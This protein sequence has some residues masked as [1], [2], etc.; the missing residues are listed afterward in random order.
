MVLPYRPVLAP[1][2]GPL[3]KPLLMYGEIMRTIFAIVSL[4]LLQI[5]PLMAAD[6]Q[7]VVFKM[8]LTWEAKG[9]N[10]ESSSGS[11]VGQYSPSAAWEGYSGANERLVNQAGYDK[12]SPAVFYKQ[13][14]GLAAL[15]PGDRLQFSQSS[16][17]GTGKTEKGCTF[18]NNEAGQGNVASIERDEHGALLTFCA[19]CLE[20]GDILDKCGYTPFFTMEYSPKSQEAMEQFGQFKLSDQELKSFKSLNKTNEMVIETEPPGWRIS[21]KVTLIGQ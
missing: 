21:V 18:A 11:A 19:A 2:D 1:L 7:P 4:C 10:G 13:L 5:S 14:G 6:Q 15:R 9:P 17:A 8:Q 3:A 12:T 16:Y 20:P